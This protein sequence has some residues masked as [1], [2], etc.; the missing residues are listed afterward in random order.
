MKKNFMILCFMI[1]SVINAQVKFDADF[2]SG[3]LKTVTTTDSVTYTVTTN[4]DIGGR[5]FYFRISG[6]KNKFIKVKVT[7][8]DV[9]RAMYS[10][11]DKTYN[12]FT[13]AESP[14]I[15][16]FQKTYEQ[17]TV[18]VSYFT[19]YTLTYLNQ[20]IENWSSNSFFTVNTF[21][22]T[23]H[24][25]PMYEFVITDP[26][27]PVEQKKVVWIH[28]R[29]HPG[30][31]PSSFHFEGIVNRLLENDEYA[32]YLRKNIEFHLV[33][34]TNP[35]GVYYGRSRTNYAGIDLESNWDKSE[36]ETAT[37]VKLL[38][39]KMTEIC[40]NN[41]F[42][43]ALNLHSIASP[44]CTFYV[45][46]AESTS[47][48]FYKRQ[49]EFTFLNTSNNPYFAQED[50]NE[51]TLRPVYPEGWLWANY[52]DTP[53]AITYETPYDYYS[54]D[55]EVSVD[56]L[57]EL[58][59]QT[60]YAISDLLE[61]SFAKNQILDNRNATVVGDWNTYDWGVKYFNENFFAAAP[62]FGTN[63]V[64]YNSEQVP[65]GEYAVFAWWQDDQDN[66]S[67]TR[68]SIYNNNGDETVIEK[69]QKTDGGNWNYLSAVKVFTPGQ[70]QI[71]VSDLANGNV[72]AD[73]FKIIYMGEISKV[74]EISAKDFTLY[75]NYPNPFNPSTTIRFQLDN[76]SNVTL[77][78]YN[79]LGQLITTLIDDK[80]NSGTH[81]FVFDAS[82]FRGIASGV[83]YY[84]LVTE[85]STYTKGM[86]LMK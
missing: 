46:T 28:A 41:V 25:L 34:F 4:Q 10:Y 81:Q 49:Y 32:E 1:F 11:D 72:C 23:D 9:V 56:N 68:F 37:E 58:G 21:G 74:E 22:T 16:L 31:T 27:I 80:L 55:I 52:N 47:P 73:A 13:K 60:V 63:Q 70:I 51:S 76:S 53:V 20:Q 42:S 19:P 24:N 36:A 12:R 79:V 61:L 35:D 62:G 18:F 69:S 54:S 65:R 71:K 45:H 85:K 67:N 15:N 86:I 17:D 50:I 43:I 30:E 40:T 5:W 2:E 83:M 14:S 7:T 3:N 66:A 8:S 48:T 59:Y 57:H 38:K 29:T 77:R 26:F 78:I 6:V 33:P 44:A 39:A 75:Q 64:V 82:Q 84:Q